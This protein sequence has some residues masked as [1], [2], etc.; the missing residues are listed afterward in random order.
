[1]AIVVLTQ[2][3]TKMQAERGATLVPAITATAWDSGIATRIALFQ[4]W[5]WDGDQP[6]TLH[7]AGIQKLNGKSY[8]GLIES[9]ASFNITPVSLPFREVGIYDGSEIGR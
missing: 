3:A 5:I 7:F 9:T 6:Q 2:C 8:H 1:M 4:D